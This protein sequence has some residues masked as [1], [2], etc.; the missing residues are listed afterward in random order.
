MKHPG[1]PQ[2]MRRP[3]LKVRRIEVEELQLQEP[4]IFSTKSQKKTFLT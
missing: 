4:E 1:N 3:N 2:S